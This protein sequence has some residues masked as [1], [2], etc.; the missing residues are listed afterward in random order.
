MAQSVI[1]AAVARY[2]AISMAVTKPPL[3]FDGIPQTDS[4]GATL[5]VPYVNLVDEGM[6]IQYDFEHNPIQTAR[7]RLE[8]YANTLVDVDAYLTGIK[9]GTTGVTAGGGFDYATFTI[10]GQ[11]EMECVREEEI[12]HRDTKIS[13]TGGFVYQ[14]TLTYSVQAKVD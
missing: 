9:Y 11:Q 8:A 12:R 10:T 5:S 1:A 6:T 4:A 14:G 3:Y 2:T 7:F 13:V